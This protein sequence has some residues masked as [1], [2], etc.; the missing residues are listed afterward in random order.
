M[1]LIDVPDGESIPPPL[2]VVRR[3]LPLMAAVGR[4]R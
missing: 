3:P 2:L 1:W 4:P